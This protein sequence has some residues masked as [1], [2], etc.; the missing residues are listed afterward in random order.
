VLGLIRAWQAFCA[1]A[2]NDK[3]MSTIACKECADRGGSVNAAFI[4]AK[5][6]ASE[7]M[8][9]KEVM[10]ILWGRPLLARQR[11]NEEKRSRGFEALVKILAPE[12]VN[13]FLKDIWR[14]SCLWQGQK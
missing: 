9:A 11:L 12:T 14:N 2:R 3:V 4:W 6:E 13:S 7:D 8:R 5:S 1:G 10:A